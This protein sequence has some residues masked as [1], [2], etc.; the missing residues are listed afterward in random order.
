MMLFGANMSQYV[1]QMNMD[2]IMKYWH[3]VINI[4]D[5]I[6][7]FGVSCKY[8]D[9]NLINLFNVARSWS[10]KGRSLTTS[11]EHNLNGMHPDPKKL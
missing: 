11:V 4:H 10:F 7:I 8:H 2:I 3:G 9:S 6:I 1:F 5:D